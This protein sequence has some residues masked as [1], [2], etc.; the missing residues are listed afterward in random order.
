[1][2]NIIPGKQA[3]G[4]CLRAIS[5]KGKDCKCYL[6]TAILIFIEKDNALMNF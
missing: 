5:Q 6:S 2:S 4:V 1:M 3:K